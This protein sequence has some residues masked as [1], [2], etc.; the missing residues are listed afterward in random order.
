MGAPRRSRPCCD[1]DTCIRQELA[2]LLDPGA[3]IV[4]R[5]VEAACE[6]AQTCAT[7]SPGDLRSCASKIFDV[8]P[9]CDLSSAFVMAYQTER[10]AIAG[11]R[12]IERERAEALA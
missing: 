6:V 8:L 9:E 2:A 3:P 11:Q 5:A 7:L 1:Q 10:D 12:L 4:D